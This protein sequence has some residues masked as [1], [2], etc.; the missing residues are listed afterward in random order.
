MKYKWTVVILCLFLSACAEKEVLDDITIVRSIGFDDYN[1]KNH[2]TGTITFPIFIDEQTFKIKSL[3]AT[4]ETARELSSELNEMT[5]KPI[6]AGKINTIL[7][8]QDLARKGIMET[9][10]TL[11]RD[12]GIG[13][14]IF[15]AVTKEK[16]KDVLTHNYEFTNIDGNY[17]SDMI[18]QNE[19][20][21]NLP[22]MNFHTFLY[23]YFAEGMDPVLP[24][25]TQRKNALKIEG[26]ALF[27]K[28]KMVGQIDEENILLFK[29]LFQTVRAG[30]YQF[31][32]K[33]YRGNL[34]ILKS[35]YRYKVKKKP[36][37]E[38]QID[39][40][41]KGRLNEYTKVDAGDPN[42][43]KGI[44]KKL[45][46]EMQK[47]GTK[48]I[49]QFQEL[50]I[51]PLGIGEHVRSK[52]RGFDYKEWKKN[53]QDAKITVNYEVEVTETGISQ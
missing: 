42:V 46:Q 37:H 19:N 27:R 4:G 1:K 40:K 23:S 6:F 12:P 48:L 2:I 44:E 22:R 35:K 29:T 49:H 11:Q 24:Y 7:F 28:D 47:K 18:K 51:D 30:S 34:E 25:L 26:L 13:R 10:D 41:L 33:S 38:V 15:L 50:N 16:A 53:Y 43:I 39:V 9:L 14:N 32:A 5:S 31:S 8:S 36:F 52:T 20:H 21:S 3:T 45:E 17:I